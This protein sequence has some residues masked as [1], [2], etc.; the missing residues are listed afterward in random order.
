[1][2]FAEAKVKRHFVYNDVG[3]GLCGR[4][5]LED[6]LFLLTS[7]ILIVGNDCG[8]TSTGMRHLRVGLLYS[9]QE[10][11]TSK[12]RQFHKMQCILHGGPEVDLSGIVVFD[13]TY[14]AHRSDWD[15]R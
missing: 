4:T 14:K 15:P 5:H 10:S 2:F 7:V 13:I 1:M 3:K 6:A 8:G 9:R 12:C 11:C